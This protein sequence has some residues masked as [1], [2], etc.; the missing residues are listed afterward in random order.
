MNL[1]LSL[2]FEIAR[3]RARTLIAVGVVVFL[4]ILVHGLCFRRQVFGAAASVAM[5]QTGG[6][7]ILAGL[8]LGGGDQSFI[9]VL[10]S[11]KFAETIEKRVHLTD[12]LHLPPG[13]AVGLL[14]GSVSP[15]PAPAE[16]L[17]YI[18]VSLEGPPYLA[19]GAAA[20][21]TRVQTA[22]ADVA[23]AYAAALKQYLTTSDMSR[24]SV[25]LRAADEQVKRAR[26]DYEE[27]FFNYASRSRGAKTTPSFSGDAAGGTATG[28]QT[29]QTTAAQTTEAGSLENLYQQ[30][31]QYEAELNEAMTR[32]ETSQTLRS[33]QLGAANQ[34]PSED[35]LLNGA[36]T[37]VTN[38]RLNLKTLRLTL[39]PDNPQVRLAQKELDLAETEFA[40]QQQGFKSGLTSEQ[41]VANVNI[42]GLRNRLETLN[43]QIAT[44]EANFHASRNRS[45]DLEYAR[46]D[47]SLKFEFLKSSYSQLANLSLQSVAGKNRMAVIDSALPAGNGAPGLTLIAMLSVIGALATCAA[48]VVIEFLLETSR[49]LYAA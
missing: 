8:G 3:R 39:G 36:R 4:A 22:V 7:G 27:A 33:N 30:R 43:R 2:L 14:M 29:S 40:A 12:A 26:Q 23:N 28:G 41:V 31:R 24:D 10:K 34:L 42:A 45:T 9:G 19:P 15:T 32:Q 37:R 38:A 6:G 17:L 1:D 49:R 21:R 18:R 46:N 16:G 35:A 13:E 25:L 48:F 47:L 44:T 11:R 5:Q 20:Q